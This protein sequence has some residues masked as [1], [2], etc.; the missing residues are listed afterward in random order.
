MAASYRAAADATGAT[1][2]PAGEEWERAR[3]RK[4]GLVLTEADGFHP[5]EMGTEIAARA[6]VRALW[7]LP[8]EQPAPRR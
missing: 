6:V 3:T 8:R 1:L 4:R 2:I 5:S 7:S